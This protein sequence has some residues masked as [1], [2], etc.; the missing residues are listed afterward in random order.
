MKL[1]RSTITI[2]QEQY[3]EIA[4]TMKQLKTRTKESLIAEV[5]ANRRVISI[6]KHF[7]KMDAVCSILDIRFGRQRLEAFDRMNEEKAGKK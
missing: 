7:S 3:N 2:T 4:T 1:T 5:R 6:D